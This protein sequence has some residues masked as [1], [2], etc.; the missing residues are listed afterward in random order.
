MFSEYV[1]ITQDV[2]SLIESYRDNNTE[3]KSDILARILRKET[4]PDKGNNH[5]Y[6][7][8]GQGAKLPVGQTIF[9]FLDLS[10]KKSGKY[11]GKAY[12]K[13]DGLYVDGVKVTPSRGSYIQPA[14]ALFQE[15]KGKVTSLSAWRQWH[16]IVDNKYVPL[17]ELKDPALARTRGR[18][19]DELLKGL[20]DFLAKDQQHG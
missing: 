11:D 13:E 9:L 12:V 3:T 4:S 1:G 20:D 6:L 16:I 8:I 14:M 18:S 7:D 2:A 5:N 15:K 10:S 17:L 19:A